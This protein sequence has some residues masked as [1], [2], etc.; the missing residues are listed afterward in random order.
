MNAV[1]LSSNEHT[2]TKVRPQLDTSQLQQGRAVISLSLPLRHTAVYSTSQHP[3]RGFNGEFLADH[4]ILNMTA[5]TKTKH[6]QL[7]GHIKESFM[8]IYY[9]ALLFMARHALPD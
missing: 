2:T 3:R 9:K 1:L 4:R 8:S 6:I 7:L 5:M